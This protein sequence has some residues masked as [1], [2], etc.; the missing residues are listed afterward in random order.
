M[1]HAQQQPG[2]EF[3][4]LDLFCLFRFFL[5]AQVFLGGGSG[6]FSGSIFS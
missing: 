4:L 6:L 3:F 2:T 5:V 1:A